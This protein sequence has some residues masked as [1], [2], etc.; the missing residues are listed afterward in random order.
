MSWHAD[1]F[2]V[3]MLQMPLR[4]RERSRQHGADLLR[5]MAL[6]QAGSTTA[7]GDEDVPARL[8]ELAGELDTSYA[9]YIAAS[10]SEMD[11]ALDSGQDSHPEIVYHLPPETVPFV[12]HIA[13]LLAEVEDYCRSDS[14]LLT[15]APP[16]DIAVYRQWSMQEVLRQHAGQPP[17]PWPAYAQAHGLG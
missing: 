7:S 3:R 9:P 12:Q 8:L 13:A 2:E 4:L 6:V 14:Y 11:A 1:L 15:L 17:T 16:P 10:T 5:E